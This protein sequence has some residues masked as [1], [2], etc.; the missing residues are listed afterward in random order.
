MG[1]EVIPGI[2]VHHGK[3]N[4]KVICYWRLKL[5]ITELAFQKKIYRA[6]EPGLK[7]LPG[8]SGI[9]DRLLCNHQMEKDIARCE[10]IEVEKNRG[11]TKLV[12]YCRRCEFA[13]PV[14]KA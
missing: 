7:Q 12:K 8:R 4:I 1:E 3:K 5:L 2:T 9:Y 11:P 6:D 13:C 10:K 14:G